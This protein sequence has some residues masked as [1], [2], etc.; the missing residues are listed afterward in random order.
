MNYGRKLKRNVFSVIFASVLIASTIAH[1][2]VAY[3]DEPLAIEYGVPTIK[4]VTCYLPTG[5]KTCTGTIPKANYTV[6][7][8]RRLLGCIVLFYKV[9]EDGSLGGF[10]TM[11]RVEDTGSH[12][13]IKGGNSFDVFQN[14]MSDARA[15]IKENGDYVYCIVIKGEG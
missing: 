6:G 2:Q 1:I 12:P 4:R 3:A 13:R 14:N 10:I 8:D 5:N 9:N 15:W 11:G 7:S